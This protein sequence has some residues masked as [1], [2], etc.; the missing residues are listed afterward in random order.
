MTLN[1]RIELL[2]A[3]LTK[4]WREAVEP[5]GPEHQPR[6]D[7]I[8]FRTILL[9][10]EAR[11]LRHAARRTEVPIAAIARL[12]IGSET[13]VGACYAAGAYPKARRGSC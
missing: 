7:L 5:Q 12:R 1:E 13:G 9:L 3:R 11:K 8:L 2:E 4:C 6:T 10:D